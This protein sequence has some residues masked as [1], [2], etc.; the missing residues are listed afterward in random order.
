M[1]DSNSTTS[2]PQLLFDVLRKDRARKDA[3]RD[4]LQKAVEESDVPLSDELL[5]CVLSLFT[6]DAGLVLQHHAGFI[7]A[8]RRDHYRASLSIMRLAI[9]DLKTALKN[10]VQV[11]T[12]DDP[13]IIL[14]KNRGQLQAIEERIEKELFSTANAAASLVD[15]VR[16]LQLKI[17]IPGFR[18][19]L[20]DCFKNDGLHELVIGLRVLLH[21][22]HIVKANWSVGSDFTTG[23]RRADFSINRQEL[24]RAIYQSGGR[25][26]GK[27]GKL[28]KNY[29][30]SCTEKINLLDL[31][32]DYDARLE[33][34]Y[35]WYNRQIETGSPE[36]LRDY[37]RCMAEKDR[38]SSR[39][40]WNLLV[41]NWLN[42]KEVPNI[43]KHLP[44]YLTTEQLDAVYE[45][46]INSTEQADLIIEF[47]DNRDAIDPDLRSK[48]HRLFERLSNQAESNNSS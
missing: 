47:I 11:A 34:F 17:E 31:F 23:D 1:I 44:D 29:I 20:T 26:N 22:L 30:A 19:K 35:D 18:E 7:I 15:H 46:P 38:R 16:R 9:A 3:K 21:H 14:A 2:S 33:C 36:A 42:R 13:G 6:T 45:L 32:T 12:I 24:E 28:I 37:D 43:H 4:A 48:I 40:V 39:T 41:S 10:F 27:Q 25:F 8:E 5:D